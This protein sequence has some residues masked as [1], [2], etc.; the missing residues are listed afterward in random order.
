MTTLAIIGGGSW[1][2]A[3]SIVLSPRFA[4]VRLW[5]Y[6]EGLADRVGASRENSLYLPGFRLPDNV[7]LTDDLARGLQDA[8]VVLLVVPSQHL[9]RVYRKCLP[10]LNPGMLF[11]NA[12]KGIETGSLRRMSEII[13][14]ES[15]FPVSVATLSGPTF[16]REIAKGEPAALVIASPD[17]HL[18][19]SVQKAFAGPNFRLYT[20]S[21]QVGVELG[22]AVKN[23]IAIGAG[24]CQGLGLGN[25]TIAAL[26]TRGLAEITRLAVAAGGQAR[27]LAGLAGLGDLVLTCTGDLS[28]NRQVGIELGKGRSLAAI[29]SSMNMIAEGVETTFATTDLA[30]KLAVEMPITN[31]MYAVLQEGKPPSEAIRYLMERALTSE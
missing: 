16:A 8:Q 9:R 12:S 7:E 31:Q 22:A 28:R 26:V 29:L 5:A 15:P 21:D 11:V 20:N 3:L 6:D 13:R 30:R 27:T 10:H 1:G 19:A 24:I 17:E 18:A 2:T 25:N 14:E 4:Q 23:V